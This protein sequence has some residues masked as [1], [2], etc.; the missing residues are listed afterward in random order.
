MGKIK[1]KSQNKLMKLTVAFALLSIVAAAKNFDYD[2]SELVG[3]TDEQREQAMQ[4]LDTQFVDKTDDNNED[5]VAL[6][7]EFEPE[8]VEEVDLDQEPLEDGEM[9]ELDEAEEEDTD[10]QMWGTELDEDHV[11]LESNENG[12]SEEDEE[13]VDAEAAGQAEM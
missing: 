6:D 7:N 8:T 13:Q 3:M 4:I 11:E 12:L 9:V 1:T 2:D 5:F 10:E